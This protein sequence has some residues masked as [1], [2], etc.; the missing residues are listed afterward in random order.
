M[1]RTFIDHFL[2][3]IVDIVTWKMSTLKAVTGMRAITVASRH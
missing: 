1:L 3:W 2:I